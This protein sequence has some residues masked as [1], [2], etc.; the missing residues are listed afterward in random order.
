MYITRSLELK[1]MDEHFAQLLFLLLMNSGHNPI[2]YIRC[3]VK[4]DIGKERKEVKCTACTH[5]YKTALRIVTVLG[6]KFR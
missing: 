5:R 2:S 4:G 3:C 6:G 1:F